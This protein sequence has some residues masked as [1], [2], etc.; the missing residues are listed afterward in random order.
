VSDRPEVIAQAIR[1]AINSTQVQAVLK[2]SA[3]VSDGTL[4]GTPSND[5]RVNII[6]A[7]SLQPLGEPA[8]E[9]NELTTQAK[10]LDLST[11]PTKIVNATIGD[12]AANANQDY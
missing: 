6:G 8:P 9:P 10:L 1:E 4:F 2:V 7:V 3:Q 5:N 11:G 12:K